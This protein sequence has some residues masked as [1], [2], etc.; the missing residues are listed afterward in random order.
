MILQTTNYSD[1][2]EFG[3]GNDIRWKWNY[4]DASD[5]SPADSTSEA[6]DDLAADCS[7]VVGKAQ[8]IAYS[9]EILA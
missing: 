3:V 1:S 9:C 6:L 4:W 5:V 8:H 7:W 2:Y